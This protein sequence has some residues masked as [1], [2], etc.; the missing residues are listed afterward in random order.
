MVKRIYK[1]F[2]IKD[3]DEIINMIL[4]YSSIVILLIM[5]TVGT[6]RYKY[7][8]FVLLLPLAASYIEMKFGI[9]KS[10]IEK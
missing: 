5:I 2:K 9:G 3:F 6:P 10:Y 4:I 7:P 8:V 1:Y